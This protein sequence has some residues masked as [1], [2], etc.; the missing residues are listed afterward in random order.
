MKYYDAKLIASAANKSQWPQSTLSEIAFVGRSNS[1][2]SSLINALLNR[3]NLAYSGK[4]PGKTR[5]LNF[6]E[7]NKELIFMDAPG[8][9]YA[10]KDKEA[11]V[12]FSNLIDPYFNERTTL[13]AMVIVL[14]SRRIPSK[15]DITMVE[16]AKAQHLPI[17]A[18]CT[19]RDKLSNNQLQSSLAKISKELKIPKE[20][21]WPCSSTSKLGLEDIWE[22]IYKY[23]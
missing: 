1:G 16:Y 19:K 8:Y 3:K 7:V 2:K 14:D 10:L 23:I 15:D 4:T 20:N 22:Q 9:G 13:K 11:A 17:I 21:L 6:Y 5:L 18:V 12:F